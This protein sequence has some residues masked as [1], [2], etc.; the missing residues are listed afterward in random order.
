MMHES[1]EN[2]GMIFS[3]QNE[4]MTFFGETKTSTMINVLVCFL[5]VQLLI[6]ILNKKE[7][8]IYLVFALFIA[9]LFNYKL[10]L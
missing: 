6:I 4:F 3:F 2:N 7:S 1:R 5:A 8:S 10:G 9:I